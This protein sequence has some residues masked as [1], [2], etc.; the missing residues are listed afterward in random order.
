[1]TPQVTF[2]VDDAGEKILPGKVDLAIGRQQKR[3][4]PEGGDLAVEN[5]DAA[6]DGTGGC[7]DQTVLKNQIRCGLS[8]QLL[9]KILYQAYFLASAK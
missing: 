2:G 3:I 9:R 8:H 1:M 7:D 4:P 5:S 6:F